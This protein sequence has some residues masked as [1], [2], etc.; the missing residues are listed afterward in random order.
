MCTSSHRSSHLCGSPLHPPPSSGQT[1]TSPPPTSPAQGLR[2]S[3]GTL[4]AVYQAPPPPPTPG[5]G[6]SLQI[7]LCWGP[8]EQSPAAPGKRL[9]GWRGHAG[10]LEGNMVICFENLGPSRWGPW[11]STS[12]SWSGESPHPLRPCFEGKVGCRDASEIRRPSVSQGSPGHLR[13][14]LGW[15]QQP[16]GGVCKE[17]I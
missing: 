12:S 1:H 7:S 15:R 17:G 6:A 16:R 3:R 2:P 14:P 10:T 13:S 9:A 4:G 11:S 8:G 5:T